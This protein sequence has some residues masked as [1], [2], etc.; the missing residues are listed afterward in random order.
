MI[1]EEY[2]NNRMAILNPP[3]FFDEIENFPR[4]CIGVF[5]HVVIKR[6]LDSFQRSEIAQLSTANGQYS[7]WKLIYKDVPVAVYT[8]LVGAP[9]CAACMEEIAAMGGR[10]FLY[11]GSCGV[12][13][14][15][16]PDGEIIVVDS[17]IRDEGTSYHYLPPS[18]EIVLDK[19]CVSAVTSALDDLNINYQTGKTWTTDAIYRETRDKLQ[20]RVESGCKTVDMECS[21]LAAVAQFR[22]YDFAQFVYSADNLGGEEYDKRSL[23]EQ[24]RSGAD[25]YIQAALEAVIRL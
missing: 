9:A 19:S 8:A 12:L 17:A 3:D 24:G 1:L 21:A 13:D 11:F 23:S 7:V 4:H 6:M 14:A 22:S 25:L 10:K 18:D 5:S 2:D 20:K 15:S 16:I